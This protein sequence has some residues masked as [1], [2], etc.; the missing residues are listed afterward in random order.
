VTPLLSVIIPTRERAGTLRYTIAT[1]LAQ[2]SQSYE[3]VVSDNASTDGTQAVVE[4]FNDPRLHYFNTGARLS[5]CDNYEFAL[6]QAR[7]RH[8]VIIGDDDAVIPGALDR[9]LDSFGES[10]E[11]LI[12]TWPLTIY[13]WPAEGRSA[14]VAYLATERAASRMDLRKHA[15]FVVTMGGWKYYELP[16]PYHCAVPKQIL[17]SIRERTGRVFHSTQPDVFTA[18]AIPAFASH[19]VNLGFAVT[20][21]GRSPRSNGLGFVVKSARANL[22]GFLSE[23]GDYAYHPTL[24]PG[25]SGTANMIPD[26][27]LR[28]CDL[29]PEVYA[30]AS[31]S[32]EAMWAYVCRL[33]FASAFDVWKSRAAIRAYQPFRAARFL[34]YMLMQ[35]AAVVRRELLDFVMPKGSFA[36]RVPDNILDFATMLAAI[37][38][39]P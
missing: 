20:L 35:E 16:S 17:D 23:Y 28:A 5:M 4:Q 9:L 12:Y 34:G 31:F 32:Y 38:S 29:F 30:G 39:R 1:A 19:A 6:Q 2:I 3:V 10:P 26:A 37:H 15:R 36:E 21:H 14:R 25:A 13:D 27:V 8:V 11:P 7:G 33:R 18:M 24:Y 22:S